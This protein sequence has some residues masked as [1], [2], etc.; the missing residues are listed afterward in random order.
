MEGGTFRS[1]IVPISV[2]AKGG[3]RLISDDEIPLK[4]SP[5]KIPS[6][7]PAFRPEWNN[8]GGQLVCER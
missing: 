3:D 4:V 8:N 7:K 6:L 2:P 5:D 1:E